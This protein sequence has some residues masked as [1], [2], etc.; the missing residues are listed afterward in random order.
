MRTTR[1][2]KWD[3]GV[4]S[5]P[6]VRSAGWVCCLLGR[7]RP[8]CQQA[9]LGRLLQLRRSCM[10]WCFSMPVAARIFRISMRVHAAAWRS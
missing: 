7:Q 9:A 8:R 1:M 4:G 3:T 6:R 10:A 5:G 2:C